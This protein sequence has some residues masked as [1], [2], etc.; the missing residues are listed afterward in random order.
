VQSEWA[1]IINAGDFSRTRDEGI[2]L[3]G[4]I[5]LEATGDLACGLPFGCPFGHVSLGTLV[6]SLAY[7]DDSVQG[8]VGLSITATVETVPSNLA[9]GSWNGADPT[10][11]GER[12]F[13]RDPVW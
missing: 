5:A 8:G 3:V 11:G 7:C 6:I 4:D 1:K 10:Q 13:G 2:D 9:G 12:G